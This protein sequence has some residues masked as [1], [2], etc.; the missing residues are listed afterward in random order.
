L[1]DPERTVKEAAGGGAPP[2]P[3]VKERIRVAAL[4]LFAERG[5]DGVSVRHI[6]TLAETTLP[7]VYYYYG[8]KMG[9]HDA[10]LEEALERRMQRLHVAKRVQGGTQMRLRAVLEAWAMPD[11]ALP[12]EV[13]LF[14]VR[15]LTGVGV[16]LNPRSLDRL[17]REL[18]GALKAILQDGIASGALRAVD[19]SM[20]VLAMIGIVNTFRRRMVLGARVTLNDGIRQATETFV[21]GL[22]AH[23]QPASAS[24]SAC[25]R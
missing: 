5:F 6:C 2:P 24:S 1:R 14:Y 19:T 13:Q 15:E 16:G 21:E 18:R 7:M 12:R 8:S 9:L 22:L 23:E 3:E 11:E 25:L 4:R 10:L 17:D 20:V